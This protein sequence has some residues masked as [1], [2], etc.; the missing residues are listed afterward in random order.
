MPTSGVDS[1]QTQASVF[2]GD[3]PLPGK[4]SSTGGNTLNNEAFMKL[5]LEQLKNQDPTA[6]MDTK[7]ILTQTA[8]LTQVEAQ[9]KMKTAM[10][11]M[12]AAMDS[13]QKTNEKTI[14]A[15]E[16]LTQTQENMLKTMQTLTNS[17]TDGNVLSGYNAVDVIGKIAETPY[18]AITISN[19][20]RVNFSL[21]FDEPI[22]TSKGNPKITITAR[23]KDAQGND[24]VVTIKEIDLQAYNGASGYLNFEWDTRDS[25]GNFVKAGEYSIAAEYNLN[26][27]TNKYLT[28]QLGR[29][30]IRSVVYDKGVPYIKLGDDFI[31]P[32]TSVQTFYSKR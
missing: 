13:M 22:D 20:D 29:G 32:I 17:I 21:Y 2:P 25:Q 28:T 15:Q 30:E 11:K 26:S 1:N 6:P 8:Q 14:Q 12:T 18:S 4:P 3:T 19:N 16:K 5:F 7:E 9:E 27:T 23:V 31:V 10:E 24:S